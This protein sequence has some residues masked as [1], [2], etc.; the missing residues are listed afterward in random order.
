MDHLWLL[1]ASI[2][3]VRTIITLYIHQ[4]W[5]YASVFG[6]QRLYNALSLPYALYS[7]RIRHDERVIRQGAWKRTSHKDA[8]HSL[9]ADPRGRQE[10]VDMQK[11][12]RI[13][14]S[15]LP[16]M[17]WIIGCSTHRHFTWQLTTPGP[18][19]VTCH[20]RPL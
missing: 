6:C 18:V 1:S 16:R 7:L 12:G 3:S 4:T 14:G 5:C 20:Q 2:L 13:C 9:K 17:S 11:N 19:P 10:A 8:S 15:P